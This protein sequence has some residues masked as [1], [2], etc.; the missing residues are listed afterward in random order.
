M[1]FLDFETRSRVNLKTV[2]TSVYARHPSTEVL[3]L[4]WGRTPDDIEIWTG[5]PMPQGLADAVYWGVEPIK[6]HNV[7]FERNIWHWICHKRF[8]W[9]DVK[10]ENWR[11]SL[12]A[13][14]RMTLPRG[15]GDAGNALGLD[16]K[17]DDAGHKLMMRLCK[18]LKDDRGYDTDPAKLQR[19]YEYCKQDVRA[20]MA[21]ASAIDSLAGAELKVWQL[22]Q[23]INLRGLAVDRAALKAALR[24]VEDT[25][26]Q[27]SERIKRIT[28]GKVQTPKQVK[29]IREI[30]EADMGVS[31]PDLAKD[32]VDEW[33]GRE[34]LTPLTRE[35]LEIRKVASKAS[36]AKLTAMLDRCDADGRVRSNL[37]YHGAAT[38]RWAG[39]GIQIQNFPRGTLAPWEIEIV[40]EVLPSGD[41]ER[42]DLLL[43]PP[44]DC[45]SSS[46]RSMITSEPGKRLLVCDFASIEARVLAWLA[47]ETDLLALF[48]ANGDTYKAM[49]SKIYEVEESDVTKPQRQ[50]GK[51]AI[52]GCGYGM[53]Y[54]AFQAACKV[55]AGIEIDRPF[56]KKVIK[57]YREA[58]P[59]I[60]QF[61]SD[62][63]TA[64]IRS[65]ET[66]KPHRV[67][68]LEVSCDDD[69][70]RIKLPSGR[71]L[72]YRK[73]ELVE[74]IAPWSEGYEGTIRGPET[75]LPQLE[76]LGIEVGTEH[77]IGWE[78]GHAKVEGWLD[79]NIPKGAMLDL[80][81]LV[82]RSAVSDVKKKEPQYIKQIQH[83]GVNSLTKKWSQ[84]RTYG[85]KLVENVTQAVARDFLAEAMVRVESKG[86][87]IV[88]SVHDEILCERTI[89]EGSLEE[90]EELMRVVPRWGNGCPIEVE[91][92]ESRRYRK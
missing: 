51:T 41:G 52:L 24:I 18:P 20:E 89:G 74:V 6:A 92:F 91:G 7:F 90:F 46:L 88:A 42:L 63:N 44:I 75:L 80:V 35:I 56:A 12:A 39:A 19:L 48:A 62:L 21:I 79:C 86:Y 30:I 8:G 71:Q 72:H 60:R 43:G 29:V 64:C 27:C 77:V 69:W 67:G 16:T 1:I 65:I 76:E 26:E 78:T 4:A 31:I 54:K 9:P 15:L 3:C 50:L 83:W 17:K 47:G 87:E 11:C 38:G 55:M 28:G 59:H 70:M 81:K 66:Q 14:S 34:D 85:G 2:G 5:G 57:A 58:N 40:H 82:G 22:D 25:Q 73:P 53:G 37:V 68:R 32:T 49:A 45:I 13:C 23:R 36:T 10:F 33:L 84:I 61:W